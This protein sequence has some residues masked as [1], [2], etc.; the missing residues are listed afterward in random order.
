MNLP[1]PLMPAVFADLSEAPPDEIA[2]LIER[3]ARE[4]EPSTLKRATGLL[5]VRVLAALRTASRQEI[6]DEALAVSR[7]IS[8]D[9]GRA[10]RETNPETFGAWKVLDGLLEEA[11]RRSDRA[12]VPGLLRGTRGM[13]ILELLAR[14]GEPV[15]RSRIRQ[16][17]D[18]GE[19]HLSHLLRDL[20]EADLILRFKP[21]GSREVLVELG[22]VGREVVS[23]SV[24]PPWLE[25]LCEVIANGS[26]GEPEALARELKEAGA[27]SALAAERLAAALARLAPDA[28]A[29]EPEPRSNVLPFVQ[30]LA[31]KPEDGEYH[32]QSLLDRQGGRPARSLFTSEVKQA[33]GG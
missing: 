22:P 5:V 23:Q 12:A 16:G 2:P 31:D 29:P 19:A 13:T 26:G 28:S 1:H 24:L 30:R 25:R 21:Q 3:A 10:L 11:A 17:L 20:E 32:F 6:L 27:P 7:G 33:A 8:G 15:P 18:L 4:G 14:E 9:A